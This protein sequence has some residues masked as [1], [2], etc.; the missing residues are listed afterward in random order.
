MLKTPKITAPKSLSSLATACLK[1]LQDSGFGKYITLGR[2]VGL[3]HYYDYRTTKDVD[4][5]WTVDATEKIKSQVIN[6]LKTTLEDFGEISVR[7]FGDVISVD[8][9]ENKQVIF[10]FQIASRSALLKSPVESPW[11]PIQLDSIDDLIASKMT[12][13]IERGAPRDFLDIYE[14]C[15]QKL[16]TVQDCWELWQK[17]ERLRGIENMDVKI[18]CEALLLHLKRIEKIRPLESIENLEQR[19]N[20]ETVR[21][22]FK[23]EFCK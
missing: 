16:V 4:A 6:L 12:A 3:A 5:W 23:N 22:W 1:A 17:R 21:K 2:A 8:V 11:H 14:S 7:R 15:K 10:N 19:E 9:K 20:A 13:L 18:G